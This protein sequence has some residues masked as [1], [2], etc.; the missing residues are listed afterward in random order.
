[1]S[2]AN[3]GNIVMV[4]LPTR[5]T[6]Y[7][8]YGKVVWRP[9]INPVNVVEGNRRQFVRDH[10]VPVLSRG[11]LSS[12]VEIEEKEEDEEMRRRRRTL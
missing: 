3:L 9:A 7:E 6:M 1:M 12:A 10:G 2:V 8:E 11:Q 5:R 4:I